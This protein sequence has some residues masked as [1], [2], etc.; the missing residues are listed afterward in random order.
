MLQE[1]IIITV[2]RGLHAKPVAQIYGI[3]N[4]YKSKAA[5]YNGKSEAFCND[6]IAVLGLDIMEGDQVFLRVE[7]EDEQGLMKELKSFLQNR[8][9]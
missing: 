1:K 5:L 3:Q 2:D 7:G 6:M 4:K 8:E 9:G